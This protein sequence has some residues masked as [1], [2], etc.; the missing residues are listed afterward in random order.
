MSR[1][2]A[3]RDPQSRYEATS[4]LVTDLRNDSSFIVEEDVMALADLL[5]DSSD[6]VRDRAAV[7][8]GLIGPRAAR[9]VPALRT[10]LDEV[11]CVR[12]DQNSSF[13]IAIALRRIGVAPRPPDC[14]ATPGYGLK[15]R[16]DGRRKR[17]VWTH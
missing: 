12:A 17:A 16:L 5:K 13:A 11:A 14:I 4:R 8:L 10:A 15:P 1:I 2:E 9:A 7:A 6:L 3:D